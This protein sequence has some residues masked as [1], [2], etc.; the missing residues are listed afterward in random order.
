M[1][2]R[3][4][5]LD[6]RASGDPGFGTDGLANY[7]KL[8][9]DM[10]YL[11]VAGADVA[12]GST[13]SISAEFHGIT[14]TTTIN[15]IADAAG[16]SFVAGQRLRLWIKGGPL[17]IANNGGGTG[18]IRTKSGSDRSCATNEIV[19]FT[20]DGTNWREES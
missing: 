15:T 6:N 4:Q 14:G 10:D 8:K 11:T 13:V 16:D 17:T 7:Q 9:G 1:A 3:L 12:S 2:N 5:A 18:N 19:C 20:Y